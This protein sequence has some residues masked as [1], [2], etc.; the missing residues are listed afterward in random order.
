MIRIRRVEAE[1]SIDGECGLVLG[2]DLKIRS[3]CPVLPRPRQE[4]RDDRSRDPAA[5]KR[6]VRHHVVD[7]RE[8]AVEH[9]LA[10]ADRTAVLT[11]H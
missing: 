5:A 4:F 11:R 8:V 6:G 1:A 3:R 7:A 10:T 2:V 9:D